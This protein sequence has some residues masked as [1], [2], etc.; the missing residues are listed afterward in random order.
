[1]R[2]PTY[3]K[4]PEFTRGK[5]RKLDSRFRLPVAAA[6]PS[7]SERDDERFLRSS[8]APDADVSEAPLGAESEAQPLARTPYRALDVRD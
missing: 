6:L 1:M 8:A 3:K 4:E 2:L 5:A 7:G